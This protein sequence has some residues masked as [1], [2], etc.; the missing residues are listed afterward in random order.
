MPFSRS[1]APEARHLAGGIGSSREFHT[2]LSDL[3]ERHLEVAGE[4]LVGSMLDWR[5]VVGGHECGAGVA[6]AAA[7][8]V[9]GRV[10]GELAGVDVARVEREEADERLERVAVGQLTDGGCEVEAFGAG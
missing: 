4:L 8:V 9:A 1:E 2:S 5:E 7:G 6:F 10:A 3:L